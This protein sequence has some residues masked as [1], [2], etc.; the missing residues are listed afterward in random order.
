MCS[1]RD[2]GFINYFG[3]QRF[4]TSTVPTYDI[5]R[6]IRVY[7]PSH[8]VDD[9]VLSVYLRCLL[10]SDWQGAIDLILKP[11]PGGGYSG[12]I[13]FFPFSHSPL[14]S[15]LPLFSSPHLSSPLLSSPLLS[16]PLLSSPLLSSPLPSSPL[17]SPPLP[18]PPLPSPPL[19]SPP[20]PSSSSPSPKSSETEE[21][22]SAR[23]YYW[24]TRDIASTLARLPKTRS[25]E[26][27]L[28]LGLQKR[29]PKNDLLG[30][31][32]FVRIK[33]LEVSLMTPN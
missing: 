5:G 32:N 13:K 17:P 10:H 3:M 9:G 25:I 11:R 6:Y 7:V 30:A 26:T 31:L 24:E 4:G 16:S 1:L 28:L 14:L 33:K 23:Q 2:V 18:S 12:A 22:S 21:L 29:G 27:Q 15:L 8:D 19:P 20:L